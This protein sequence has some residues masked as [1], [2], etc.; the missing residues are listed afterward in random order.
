MPLKSKPKTR[1]NFG[2]KFS[3]GNQKLSF[4]EIEQLKEY[5][6]TKGDEGAQE[7]FFKSARIKED[8][9]KALR[10][11]EDFD[12]TVGGAEEASDEEYDSEQRE[13]DSSTDLGEFLYRNT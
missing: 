12:E 7:E 9:R 10:E 6:A 8:A 5:L 2:R 11:S 3:Q 1:I 4:E 13:D